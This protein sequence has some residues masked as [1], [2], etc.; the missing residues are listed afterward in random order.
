MSQLSTLVDGVALDV[1]LVTRFTTSLFSKDTVLVGV[2]D[3][4]GG[5]YAEF[6]ML[7]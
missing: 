4:V 6:A 1:S 2:T 3:A 7:V 5:V